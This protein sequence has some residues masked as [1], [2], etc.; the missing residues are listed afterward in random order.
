MARQAERAHRSSSSID[1]VC[2]PGPLHNPHDRNKEVRISRTIAAA[3]DR[4][5]ALRQSLV[6]ASTGTLVPASRHCQLPQGISVQEKQLGMK[7]T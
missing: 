7:P 2:S 1:R 4:V 6:D 5:L 3:R